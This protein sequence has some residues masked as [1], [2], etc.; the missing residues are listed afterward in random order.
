MILLILFFHNMIRFV[1]LQ[2]SNRT[3]IEDLFFDNDPFSP[4][5]GTGI[6]VEKGIQYDIFIQYLVRD[7]SHL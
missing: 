5:I 7:R 3:T 6:G 1:I 2:C 4:R